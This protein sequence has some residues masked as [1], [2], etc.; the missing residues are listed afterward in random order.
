MMQEFS[1][2]I[3]LKLDAGNPAGIEPLKITL[4]P[5]ATPIRAKQRRCPYLKRES[6]IRYV[7][8]LL[9]LGCVKKVSSPEWVSVPLVVPKRP[10]TMYCLAIDYRPV[11]AV[12][13]QTLA[14]CPTSRLN[15]LIREAP[16]LSP[17]SFSAVDI[18][19]L[20]SIREAS[21]SSFSLHPME[22]SC[23]PVRL[24]AVVI[25]RRNSKRMPSS[26]SLS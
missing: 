15:W 2:S 5:D 14:K 3:K 18:S 11:N 26:A 7:R 12:L 1:D 23:K 22:F 19:K 24:K 21:L 20:Y 8:E 9:K 6:M 16:R 17:S 13:V 25:L 4:K 10:P